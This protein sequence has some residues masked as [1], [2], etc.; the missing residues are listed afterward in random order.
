VRLAA[1]R[2]APPLADG[3][4]MESIT[5]I[6]AYG[7]EHIGDAA[8]LGGVLLRAHEK[9]GTKRGV[10]MTQRPDHTQRL[11]RLLD[12][13]VELRVELYE[14]DRIEAAV[15]ETD[16]VVYAGGPL[17]DLPKQLVRHL[18]A[19]SLAKKQGKP[20]VLEG[21]GAGPFERKPS[22]W[23]GR[24]ITLAANRISIRTAADQECSILDGLTPELGHDPAFDYLASRG[25][26]LSRLP[27]VDR[28]WVERLVADRED[29]QIVGLNLRP[30]RPLFT[31]GVPP[32]QRDSYTRFVERR[33]EERLAEAMKIFSKSRK[34]KVRY[35]YY[36][37]NAIQFGSSDLKSAYRLARHLRSD[38][39]FR[40][41][42]GDATLDGVVA[43][44]RRIDAVIAMRFHANI[45]A[46]SQGCAVVGIDYRPGKRDKVD[47]LLRDRGLYDNVARI[48]AMT[49][50]WLVDA[51][52]RTL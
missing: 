47:A 33:F 51:L 46:L 4:Q 40:V 37:M 48:D 32:E 12:T 49:V 34:K 3:T 28:A 16:G 6:G 45:F 9:F 44:L 13:P 29:K 17:M 36:P 27:D 30:I 38:V 50:D 10:L 39:D 52:G 5:L 42:E 20:I 2:A 14:H 26:E 8:I 43:L 21:I 24:Q 1:E 11:V 19:V 41:W 23:V 25:Q 22:E 31:T 18:Y 35:V 7:G 15:A